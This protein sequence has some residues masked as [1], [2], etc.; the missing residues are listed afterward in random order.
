VAVSSTVLDDSNNYH[1]VV[2]TV[3]SDDNY[4]EPIVLV[5]SVILLARFDLNGVTLHNCWG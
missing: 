3:F 5:L 2:S 1:Y 4:G